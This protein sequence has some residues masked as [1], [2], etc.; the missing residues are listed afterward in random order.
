MFSVHFLFLVLVIFQYMP[1]IPDSLGFH[2]GTQSRECLPPEWKLC[3]EGTVLT[4]AYFNERN[5]LIYCACTV[6]SINIRNWVN[7]KSLHRYKSQR[8]ST[9]H[10]SVGHSTHWCTHGNLRPFWRHVEGWEPIWSSASE[11]LWPYEK[12]YSVFQMMSYTIVTEDKAGKE[13]Y[14]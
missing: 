7:V 14:F 1:F 5:R 8:S 12:L 3:C 10:K 9:F 4:F 13:Q 11:H 6:T 2:S